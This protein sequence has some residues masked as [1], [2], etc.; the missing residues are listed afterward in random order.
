MF[1]G[2]ETH[3]SR[4]IYAGGNSTRSMRDRGL[5]DWDLISIK[6]SRRHA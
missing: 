1:D 3:N 6:A 2:A 4:R 5:G